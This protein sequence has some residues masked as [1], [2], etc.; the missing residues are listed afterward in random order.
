MVVA[1]Q[2]VLMAIHFVE[3]TFGNPGILVSAALLGLTDMDALT[4]SM[5]RIGK[6][7]AMVALAARAVAI[8]ILSNTVLKLA[9]TL[10]L[11]SAA[12]RRVA[13]LG[14]GMLAL[15]TLAGLWIGW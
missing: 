15:A 1:L 9:V 4:L 3:Q 11:G 13:S 14:L 12:F 2:L 5:A 6:S 8:G 7:E 10:A